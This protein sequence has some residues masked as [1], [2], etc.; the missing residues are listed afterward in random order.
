MGFPAPPS[1][2]SSEAR[3][4]ILASFS[5]TDEEVPDGPIPVP[6]NGDPGRWFALPQFLAL[7]QG[8][9]LPIGLVMDPK[10]MTPD[11]FVSIMAGSA[12]SDL[13][14]LYYWLTSPLLAVW[15]KAVARNPDPFAAPFMT[16]EA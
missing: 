1:T 5:L 4:T 16:W 12:H 13:N 9:A 7:P 8:H 2:E 15:L 3:Y 11:L 14:D 6:T 10:K